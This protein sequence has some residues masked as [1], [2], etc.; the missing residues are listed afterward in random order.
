M[1]PRQH[2]NN[3]SAAATIVKNEMKGFVVLPRPLGNRARLL[4][5]PD[6]I[7]VSENL[8]ETL[9]TFGALAPIQLARGPLARV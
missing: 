5:A 1:R 3:R 8:A 6:E 7:G 9:S 4:L 2:S